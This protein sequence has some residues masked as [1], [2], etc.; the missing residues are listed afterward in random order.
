MTDAEIMK[1][2]ECCSRDSIKHCGVCS[3]DEKETDTYCVNYLI[4]DAFNLINRQKAEIEKYENIK[5]TIHEFWDILLKI[6]LAKRKESP[7]LEELAD[8]LEEIKTE[9]IKEFAER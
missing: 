4:K 2:L 6:K 1:A 5:T 3:Y 8:A 7:T 9:A